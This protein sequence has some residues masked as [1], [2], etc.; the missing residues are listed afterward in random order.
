MLIVAGLGRCGL[1][2]TMQMLAAGGFPCVGEAPAYEDEALLADLIE[3]R[4]DAMRGKAVKLVWGDQ[5]PSAPFAPAVAIAMTRDRLEQAASTFKLVQT[6]DPLVAVN[7]SPAARRALAVDLGEAQDA[8]YAMLQRGGATF[9]PHSF[10]RAL[11]DPLE[12]AQRIELF[13]HR[14]FGRRFDARAA[15]KVVIKRGPECQPTMDIEFQMS[16]AIG[17]AA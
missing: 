2:L 4:H 17:G 11:A 5:V 9:I 12:F 8:L 14:H 13:I 3:G 6:F 16:R 7:A 15:A 1:T 10:E